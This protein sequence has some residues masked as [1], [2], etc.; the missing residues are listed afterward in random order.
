M[1]RASRSSLKTP[2]ASL[3]SSSGSLPPLQLTVLAVLGE[4][5]RGISGK[6]QEVEP[7]GIHR[8]RFQQLQLAV[9]SPPVGSVE[10]DQVVAQ[11]IVGA[12][13]ETIQFGHCLGQ[14]V[15]GA[16]KDQGLASL[17]TD[18]SKGPDAPAPD[19]NFQVNR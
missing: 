6:G 14:A 11:Q 10:L 8:R 7:E 3:A 18:P 9:R 12:I 5:M 1:V 2:M 15:I 4:V 13:G 17:P 16:R 19:G